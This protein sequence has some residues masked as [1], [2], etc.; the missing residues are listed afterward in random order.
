MAR[1]VVTGGAGFIGSHVAGALAARGDRVIVLDDL[2]SG[3]EENLNAL[4]P[5]VDLRQVDVATDPL[6]AHFEGV[7]TVFHLAAIPSVE[8]SVSDPIGTHRANVD[9]TL[10]VLGAAQMGGVRRWVG[11]SSAAVY[12][13]DRELPKREDMRPDPV[14]PYGAHK[15]VLEIYARAFWKTYGLETVALRY[16]NVFGPRQDPES[17]YTGV[18]ARFVS[19]LLEGRTPVI[20][21][22]GTQS[23][24]FV[25]VDDVVEANLRASTADGV[26][27]EVFNIAG[28]RARSINDLLDAIQKAMGTAVRP[29]HEPPRRGDIPH[30]LA[31]ITRA[32]GVLDWVP[33]E[34][35]ADALERT[36]AWYQR[37]RATTTRGNP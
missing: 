8:R 24:D 21:G 7:D 10:R 20:F 1:H 22:D 4:G 6:A 16:F 12:G 28:G 18:M 13:D 35:F 3:K 2:S 17:P 23:R 15:A 9:G 25:A 14:S 36:I 29:I 11:A 31:D 37:F 19:K 26:A 32:G 34:S 30:S 33:R 27:G 5:G